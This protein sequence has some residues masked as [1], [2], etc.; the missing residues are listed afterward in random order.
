MGPSCI[1]IWWPYIKLNQVLRDEYSD[2]RRE[3]KTDENGARTN[4]D[5]SEQQNKCLIDINWM[6]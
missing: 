1:I 5:A 6:F 2:V 4:N 3:T